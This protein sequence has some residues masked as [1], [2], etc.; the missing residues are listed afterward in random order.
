MLLTPS[1]VAELLKSGFLVYEEG[2]EIRA[3]YHRYFIPFDN[4]VSVAIERTLL[5]NRINI[6]PQ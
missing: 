1:G 6:K 3:F 4:I 2:F 5:S